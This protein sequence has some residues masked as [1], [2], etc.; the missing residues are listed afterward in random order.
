M[1]Y[2]LFHF[3]R[4][5]AILLGVTFLIFSIYPFMQ[6]HKTSDWPSVSGTITHSQ[7]REGGA[8]F[9]GIGTIYHADITFVYQVDGKTMSGNRVQYGI[10]GKSFIF[11]RFAEGM[12]ERYPVG[13]VTAIYYNPD[14]PEDEIIESAPVLGFS[15]IWILFTVMFF[16]LAIYLTVRKNVATIDQ[17][18]ENYPL[19][20]K[21]DGPKSKFVDF[22]PTQI[23]SPKQ[24]NEQVNPESNSSEVAKSRANLDPNRATVR[25]EF[26]GDYPSQI[27]K[28]PTA[29]DKNQQQLIKKVSVTIPIIGLR[30]TLILD[31]H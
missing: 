13:K 7:L 15:F 4:N 18:H 16:T 26:A 11:Q 8:V 27:Y 25:Q 6:Y 28:P 5:F 23:Y 21:E 30:L 20:P 2:K 29:T 3:L 17:K 10:G 1:D 22:Y 12:V 9:L 19:R 31:K 14:N 24:T